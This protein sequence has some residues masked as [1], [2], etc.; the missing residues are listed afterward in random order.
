VRQAYAPPQDNVLPTAAP[1]SATPD[2]VR[3]LPTQPWPANLPAPPIATPIPQEDYPKP[4]RDRANTG[5]VPLPF[6]GNSPLMPTMTGLTARRITTPVVVAGQ[7]VIVA[8]QDGNIYGFDRATGNQIWKSFIDSITQPLL[9]Q[10]NTLYYVDSAT[11]RAV[12]IPLG[13]AF[14]LWEVN[15]SVP[16][17]SFNVQPASGFVAAGNRLY[18]VVN[19]NG[20]YYVVQM[21]RTAGGALA[22]FPI[23]SAPPQSLAIGAQMLYVAGAALWALDLDNLEL[24]WSRTDIVNFITPPLYAA[25]G[26][27]ALAELY[28]SAGDGQV[29]TLDANTGATVQVYQSGN[30]LPTGLALGDAALYISGPNFIKAFERR[31]TGMLWT[32]STNGNAPGGPIVTPDQIILVSDRGSIQLIHPGTGQLILAGSVGTA[33]LNAPA[34]GGL[35]LFVPG[36]DGRVYGFTQ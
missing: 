30:Q 1:P 28:V 13:A 17:V 7:Y 21:D 31:S 35:V 9:V 24:V 19:S 10:D 2:D 18:L 5:R 8:S 29:Y 4:R 27:L 36:E 23:G 6:T 22:A 3:W 14:P 20:I 25:N 32:I 16:N 15:L 33:V 26:V 11:N 34:V 12:A